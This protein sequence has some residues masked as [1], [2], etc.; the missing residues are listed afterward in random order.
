M[1]VSMEVRIG[2]YTIDC[3]RHLLDLLDGLGAA[4]YTQ[5]ERH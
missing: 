5:A 2:D 1:L 4:S 3:V